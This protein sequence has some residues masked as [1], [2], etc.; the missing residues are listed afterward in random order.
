[1]Y[2]VLLLPPNALMFHTVYKTFSREAKKDKIMM[3]S[4][5]VEVNWVCVWCAS[6]SVSGLC[7]HSTFNSSDSLYNIC[8]FSYNLN[9][10]ASKP[11]MY[12]TYVCYRRVYLHE[13]WTESYTCV[14]CF[15]KIHCL[16][17]LLGSAL[18]NAVC[19]IYA[20]VWRSVRQG[21]HSKDFQRETW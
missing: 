3:T 11:C 9:V 16:T 15:C 13:N 17:V 18:V 8:W 5:L 6:F 21:F 1:M 12:G 19:V 2:F 4:T 7:S 14:S 10:V 20:E